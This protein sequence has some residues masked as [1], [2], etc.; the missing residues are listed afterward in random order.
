MG[1][2]IVPKRVVFGEPV[3]SDDPPPPQQVILEPGP[4]TLFIDAS[5]NDLLYH[6]EAWYQF[7]LTCVPHRNPGEP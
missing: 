4:H 1:D 2:A 5:T 3:V 6:F 7:A